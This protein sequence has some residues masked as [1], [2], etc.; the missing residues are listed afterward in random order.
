MAYSGLFWIIADSFEEILNGNFQ[1]AAEKYAVDEQGKPREAVSP[2]RK[3]HKYIWDER[4]KEK[5]GHSYK[6]Y[7]RGS[8]VAGNKRAYMNM[9][10]DT[11]LSQVVDAVTREFELRGLEHFPIFRDEAPW[12]YTYEL[13]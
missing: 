4:F 8:V 12:Y 6:Y 1:L 2:E 9:H 5:Y 3:S 7:P 13:K 11:Y 10:S